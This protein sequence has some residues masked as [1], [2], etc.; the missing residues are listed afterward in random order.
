MRKDDMAFYT[1]LE[2]RKFGFAA[3]G[4]DVLISDKAT[5]YNAA[6]IHIGDNVRIDDF[7]ILSAGEGGIHLGKHVHI[8]CYV[9]LIG[10]AR[11]TLDDFSGISSRSAIYSSNDDYSGNF[12][13]GPTVPDEYKNV[14]HKEVRIGRHVVVGAFGC[15]LPGVSIGDGSATGAYS[16]V[17]KDVPAGVIAA[18]V[19]VKVLKER[20]S[21]MFDLE[22][23]FLGK[24]A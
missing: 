23:E 6:H 10:K 17:N 5:I 14:S 21:R 4:R 15:V 24:K 7:V 20:S 2:L 9:S 18:G 8:A 16:L 11:I 12:L 22:R 1:Q 3:L 19:P 13:T